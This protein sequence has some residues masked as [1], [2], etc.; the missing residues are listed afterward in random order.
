[1][2]VQERKDLN[3]P[4]DHPKPQAESWTKVEQ[5]GQLYPTCN[6]VLR[7][8]EG[9][10]YGHAKALMKMHYGHFSYIYVFQLDSYSREDNNL[11]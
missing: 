4:P 1:M 7:A 2:W 3:H 11:D 6:S 5:L 9:Y 10:S 8:T